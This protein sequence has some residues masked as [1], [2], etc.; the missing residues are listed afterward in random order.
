MNA[1]SAVKIKMEKHYALW[2]ETMFAHYGHM[3][4]SLNHG[5]MYQYD[6]DEDLMGNENVPSGDIVAKALNSVGILDV[7][8]VP[9]VDN[10]E[11][12]QVV[13]SVV[14]KGFD[15]ESVAHSAECS[16]VPLND[17]VAEA[18]AE[19]E[20]SAANSTSWASI[21]REEANEIIENNADP[22]IV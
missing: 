16:E 14:I 15:T 8:N 7:G 2:Q 12:Y 9:A 17:A 6:E 11:V 22:T 18:G 1:E 20:G 13:A 19:C 3:W 10:V 21:T 5:P 4:V